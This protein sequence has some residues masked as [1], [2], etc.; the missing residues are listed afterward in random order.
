[1]DGTIQWELQFFLSLCFAKKPRV[2]K[3]QPSQLQNLP[4]V[5]GLA[6]S[7][8]GIDVDEDD[9]VCLVG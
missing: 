9:D 6:G 7:L 1:M 4:E 8:A 2:V 5:R 3:K